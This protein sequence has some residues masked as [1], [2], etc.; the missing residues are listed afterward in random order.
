M[1]FDTDTYNP[2]TGETG[3]LPCETGVAVPWAMA[4][5]RTLPVEALE[6]E[7]SDTFWW[8]VFLP[9]PRLFLLNFV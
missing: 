8:N 1:S 2:R 5:A 3:L 7:I 9:Y 4:P 6:T